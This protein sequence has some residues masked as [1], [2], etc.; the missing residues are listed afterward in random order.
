MD[1]TTSGVSSLSGVSSGPSAFSVANNLSFNSTN[2]VPEV[3]ILV[4]NRFADG[5]N[6]SDMGAGQGVY[7]LSGSSASDFPG[8]DAKT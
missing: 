5:R 6:Y 4:G 7:S 3:G 1:G 8:F 2:F